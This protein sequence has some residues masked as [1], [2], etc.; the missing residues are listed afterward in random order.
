MNIDARILSSI[1][2]NWIKENT[3]NMIYHDQVGFIAEVQGWINIWKIINV[4][5]HVHKLKEKTH[6]IILL[7]AEKVLD[8]NLALLNNKIDIIDTKVISNITKA[9]NNKPL[10]KN[11]LNGKKLKIIALKS[12]VRKGCS[13]SPSLFNIVLEVLSKVVVFNLTNAAT[14]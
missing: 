1:L 4:I 14:I 11:N 6:R 2:A 5:H 7:N 3:R 13:L 8:K 10:T 12:R 9:V